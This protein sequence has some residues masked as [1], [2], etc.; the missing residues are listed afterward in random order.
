MHRKGCDPLP[1]DIKVLFLECLG[2]QATDD[3][4]GWH[5]KP[6]LGRQVRQAHFASARLRAASTRDDAIFLLVEC[7]D[8]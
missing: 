7:F 3:I 6:R 8:V 2:D 1:R 4:V 5:V